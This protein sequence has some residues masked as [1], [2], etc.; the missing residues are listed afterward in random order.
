MLII[1]KN[2]TN[3]LIATVSMNKTL[4]NPYYLFSF[5]H[6]TSKERVS[7]IPEVITSNV[8][9]D[10]FRFNEAVQTNLSL[11]PPQVNFPYI[12]QW[13]YAI[14][15]QLSPTNT[16]IE[17]VYNK[18]E[19]GRAV[20]IVGNDQ[21]QECFF[22]PYV[23]QN[24]IFENIIYI[25]EQEEE[26][27]NPPL[28]QICSNIL[29]GSCPS[30][31]ANTYP[32]QILF[33]SGSTALPI[34]QFE[35]TCS[36]SGLAFNSNTNK[37][38][39]V[40]GCSN[41]YEYDYNITSGGCFNLQIVN[42]W[43]LWD[44]QQWSAT[45][46]ASYAMNVYDDNT[47]IIGNMARFVSQTGTT[48]YLYDLTTSGLTQWLEIGNNASADAI[49]YNTG[50]TQSIVVWTPASGSTTHY[51]LYSGSS[52]PQLITTIVGSSISGYGI[53]FSG[54][55]AIAVNNA[56]LQ[57]VLDFV[58]NTATLLEDNT[59]PIKYVDIV[60]GDFNY[61][62][63]GNIKQT[64]DC[65]NQDIPNCLT[66]Q[67][68]EVSLSD[69]TKFKLALWDDA[70]FTSATN[71]NCDY[72]ISG[73]AFGSLGTIYTGTET[74]STNQHQHQFNLASVLLPGEVVSS[75]VVHSYELVGCDCFV[76]IILP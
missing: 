26:C 63:L 39:M 13:Y 27:I 74:I 68:L 62:Y 33:K 20:V 28:P 41:Y 42:K 59:F 14:Y 35:D 31:I 67:Y 17:K 40:D 9:Y 7:F 51:S 60:D 53:Y 23:S 44:T 65:Y 52:N 38:Y 32:S 5:Q 16:D 76:D 3:N 43:K 61:S 8:R 57:W 37:M 56:G 2:Q 45:P 58:N 72:V 1:R 6:I 15:E 54:N 75:F 19:A 36:P 47:L 71:A 18:L 22:E 11:T 55:T 34:Y 29:T 24:E 49:Y 21:E 73:T 30:F 66:T 69:S 12:G 25:S 48:F 64:Q 70:G 46:N 10:K 50:N 4:P